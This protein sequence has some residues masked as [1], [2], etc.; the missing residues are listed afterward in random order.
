MA[1]IIDLKLR[2]WFDKIIESRIVVFKT[3]G[4]KMDNIWSTQ[5]IKFRIV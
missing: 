2:N 3:V 4:L 1:F 5:A